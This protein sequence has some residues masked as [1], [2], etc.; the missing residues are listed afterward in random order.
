MAQAEA[1]A[2]E[3][4]SGLEQ[5]SV[6]LDNATTSAYSLV[7]VVAAD[8]KGLVYDL[9]RTLKDIH[10]RVAYAKV[11]GASVLCRART[12]FSWCTASETYSS[13]HCLAAR[14]HSLQGSRRTECAALHQEVR[15]S[16]PRWR[17]QKDALHID[18]G[19][20]R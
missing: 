14:S 20:L 1:A 16:V 7:T 6:T 5:V 8:R 2:N 17:C 19:M 3:W 15:D 11:G 13:L 10:L 12:C 4:G 9:M 18:L